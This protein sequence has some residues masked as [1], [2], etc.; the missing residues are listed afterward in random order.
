MENSNTVRL[1]EQIE[2]KIRRGDFI[3]LGK[4]LGVEQ[5]TAR[6][7]FKRGKEI[8]I[9][10]MNDILENREDFEANYALRE[11]AVIIDCVITNGLKFLVVIQYE[12]KQEFRLYENA[13][14]MD[15]MAAEFI[16]DVLKEVPA[17]IKLVITDCSIGFLPKVVSIIR[18]FG[19]KHSFKHSS[20]VKIEALINRLSTRN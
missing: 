3:T 1:N 11:K 13:Q 9:T 15:M 18:K 19:F 20:S 16:S 6:M 10:V 7:Q 8:A 17:T 5:N 12:G 14:L 4:I 2:S